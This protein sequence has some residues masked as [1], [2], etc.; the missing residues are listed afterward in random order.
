METAKQAKG[1]VQALR[2]RIGKFP[3]PVSPDLLVKLADAEAQFVADTWTPT[4]VW[5]WMT[6]GQEGVA[7]KEQ[8]DLRARMAQ[9]L[10]V[11]TPVAPTPVV[12]PPV[13]KKRK[14]A[15]SDNDEED[16]ASL[17]AAAYQPVDGCLTGKAATAMEAMLEMVVA[18]AG[19]PAERKAF[20]SSD[21]VEQ[22]A[23]REAAKECRNL[24]IMHQRVTRQEWCDKL[25]TSG[26]RGKPRGWP[27][28]CWRSC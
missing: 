10:P 14:A 24:Q 4:Q 21:K 17:T 12:P 19:A 26:S 16:L 3:G 23:E 13:V 28:R 27:R 7:Q 20:L 6:Q 11:P 8:A 25:G 2:V 1:M 5:D 22:D 18:N 15:D 9:A